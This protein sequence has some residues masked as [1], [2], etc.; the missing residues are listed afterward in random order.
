M[1]SCLVPNFLCDCGGFERRIR[2]PTIRGSS[3]STVGHLRGVVQPF[4]LQELGGRILASLPSGLRRG[5]FM[6]LAKRRRGLC[7]TRIGQVVLVLSGRSRRRFGASGVA[8]LTRLAGLHR[9][10]YSPS[11]VFTSCGT[12]STGIS[13]YLGVVDGTIRDKRGVLLF[14]RF[15]AVLSRLTGHLRR[16]GVDCC[17]LANSADG[18]GHTRVM[19]G[20]G[21]SGARMFYVSLGTKK[22]NLGLATT[23]VMVRFSP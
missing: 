16:R 7:S 14:S 18:R 22:A 1:F 3:R 15:A 9:V 13:V 17:V 2:V 5:V 19:R 4:M 20:F 23:S 8:V 12:S 21:A 6:R 10:Y 11:L